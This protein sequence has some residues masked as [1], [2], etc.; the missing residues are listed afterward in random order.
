MPEAP[1]SAGDREDLLALLAP[2][3]R[4][5]RR[6]EEEAA[7]PSGLSMW[8]Y[9]VLSVVAAAPGLNQRQVADRLDY[10]TNRIIADLD[11]LERRELLRRRPGPDRRS[12]LLDATEAGVAVVREIRARIRRGEEQLLARLPRAERETWLAAARTLADAARAGRS[13]GDR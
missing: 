8:Q 9:A 4:L 11:E 2:V 3:A 1:D 6:V 13:A 10:S 7:A 5:L 12:N